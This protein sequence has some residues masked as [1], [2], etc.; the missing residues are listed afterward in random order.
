VVLENES[1]QQEKVLGVVGV[2]NKESAPTNTRV[3]AVWGLKKP[4]N[5]MKKKFLGFFVFEKTRCYDIG[6][7]KV[8]KNTTETRILVLAALEKPKL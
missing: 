1:L 7:I 6:V 8:R 4:S 5:A 2:V 3:L